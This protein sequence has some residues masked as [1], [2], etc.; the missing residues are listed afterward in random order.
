MSW[1]IID[2]VFIT[3]LIF[4][5]KS[6]QC[7]FNLEIYGFI[8]VMMKFFWLDC[9]H[10]AT[11]VL[12]FQGLGPGCCGSAFYGPKRYKPGTAGRLQ[13]EQL[14]EK[15]EIESL[16]EENKSSTERVGLLKEARGRR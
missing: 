13:S 10:E 5:H 14:L 3:N 12:I 11:Y 15:E 1:I 9:S 2:H 7:E 8:K 16:E 4:N 6:A